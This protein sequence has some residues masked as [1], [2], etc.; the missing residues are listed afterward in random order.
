[1]NKRP[2]QPFRG[3]KPRTSDDAQNLRNWINHSLIAMA[4]EVHVLSADEDSSSLFAM[5]EDAP[6]PALRRNSLHAAPIQKWRAAQFLCLAIGLLDLSM[7]ESIEQ[8]HGIDWSEALF[9]RAELAASTAHG[10][11]LALHDALHTNVQRGANGRRLIGSASRERV[12]RAALAQPSSQSKEQAAPAIAEAVGL[13]P[14]T[15]RKMLSDL[16][17]GSSWKKRER[18]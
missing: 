2:D 15:V 8:E 9:V 1:V 17:P 4:R 12:R 11:L 13:A 16:F 7:D 10:Y 3:S 5:A 14:G 6:L 18:S